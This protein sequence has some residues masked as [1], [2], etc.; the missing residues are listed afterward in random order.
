[1][2][3]TTGI[4]LAVAAGVGASAEA[5]PQAQIS[6][7]DLRVRLYLPD[8][9]T[10]FYRGTR[11]DW[12]GV[13]GGLQYAGHEFYPQWFQRTD[14][15]VHDFIYEG[16]DIV[17]GPCTAV[18]GP[19]EEFST[20]GKALGFDEAKPGGTF[21]KIGIGV[22]RRPDDRPYDA[23]HLYE[24]VDGGRWS[25]DKA[26][27][28]VVF[29][30]TVSDPSTGYGYEYRKS[31][32][33]AKDQPRLVLEHRLRNTGKRP[34]S[35]SV[36]NHN[37]LYLDRQPPSPDFSL[38]MAF[39]F[40]T[41]PALDPALA[42]VD[43]NRLVFKKALAGEEKVYFTAQGYSSDPK[44]YD[45]RIENR[46]AGVGV[47]IT[48]DRPLSKVAF[49]CIRAP[50]CVEPFISMDIQPGADFAWRI[51]YDHYALK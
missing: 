13:I 31:V 39:P 11:F 41:T 8:A 14:A 49:W 47:R 7:N 22:L 50:L 12:S 44:D 28:A 20:N 42:A 30:Q 5:A 29:T 10:G 4:A 24:I 43:G 15:T 23:Y 18:T 32:S 1:M 48:A 2:T 16:N 33:L 3:K 40:Q 51:Q 26:D 17:A 19:V 21:I 27:S 34:L 38:A 45:F 46:T 25:V 37:F 6:N 9:Q 36:Y 35:T